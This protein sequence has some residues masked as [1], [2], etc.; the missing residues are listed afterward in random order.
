MGAK[1][2]MIGILR[3]SETSRIKFD[4]TSSG[5]TASIN[6]DTFRRI[7]TGLERGDFHVVEGKYTE[8]KLAYSAWADSTTGDAANTFYL[9]NNNRTSRDFNALVVHESVHAFFDLTSTT[10]PWVDNEAIAYIAQG[11]Y[12]RNSG[13]PESR[14]KI[15][16]HNRVG[17]LIAG[18]FAQ[19]GDASSMISDLR[20]NLLDD[21][22][23]SHYITSTFHGDG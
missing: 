19:G 14:M 4:Y 15:G 22:R 11:F 10:I 8:D 17:Y 5:A 3:S 20:Q 1:E 23:Y 9:G 18:T 2:Q 16:E 7:A 13:F 21:T 12:L 6:G